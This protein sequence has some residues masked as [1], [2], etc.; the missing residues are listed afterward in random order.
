MNPNIVN[1]IIRVFFFT[2]AAFG[3]HILVLSYLELPLFENQIILTYAVNIIFGLVLFVLLFLLRNR[4]K[5][6]IGFI[7]I[8]SSA[9]KFLLFFALFTEGYMADDNFS[10]IEFFTLFIPYIVV[11]VIEVFSLSLWLNK[12]Q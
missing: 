3:L 10:R 7:F 8:F 2:G 5:N 9:F 12:L 6:Q 11:L 1:F 4:M